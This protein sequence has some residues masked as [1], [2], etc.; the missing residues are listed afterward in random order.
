MIDEN[1]MNTT[2]EVKDE[3]QW[4][5]S[6]YRRLFESACDGI[7]ILDAETHKIIDV[8]PFML[9]LLGARRDEVIGRELREIGLLKDEEA[10]EIAFQELEAKGDVHYPV[11]P[12]E[13]YQGNL[14]E[15]EFTGGI[16]QVGARRIVQ[17]NIRDITERRRAERLREQQVQNAMMLQNIAGKA[18]HL[19]GWS[20]E[21]PERKLAWS[22]ENCLIH[23]LPP[24]YQPTLK[25]GLELFPEEHRAEVISYVERC[26]EEGLA[27]EF[28]LPKYT[29]KGRLIWVRSV[30]EAVR[31]ADGKIIRLQG[32]FQ[33]ITTRKQAEQALRES[34]EQY[35]QIIEHASDIIYKTNAT[36]RFS[37]VNPTIRK[38]LQYTEEELLSMHYLDVIRPDQRQAV[39][40]TYTRQLVRKT[41]NTYYELIAVAKDGTELW[42]GQH[43]QLLSKDNRVIGF[44]AICR[45]ITQKKQTEDQLRHLALTDE[46]TGLYN[47]R[48]FMALAEHQLKLA[49]NKR[50]EKKLLVLYVDLDGLKQINDR[51]GHDEGSRAIIRTAEILKQSF[52]HSDL[53]ARLGGDEFVVLAI[54]ANEEN[55]EMIIAR[56]QENFKNHNAQD[57][58]PCKIA[59]SFGIARFESELEF[60][61]ENLINRADEQMYHQKKRK[62]EHQSIENLS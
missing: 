61:I 51:F 58:H 57:S 22:D 44:Q 37:F 14:L 19:G 34:E 15:V 55:T 28:E 7:F 41:P 35:K 16:C 48:G 39:R 42:L 56:L 27:Y 32:A 38:I 5:D 47:R 13:T 4:S 2:A 54:E 53:V 8:N 10:S 9:E 50:I 45:D 60:Q 59:I 23:D 33:D 52:R 40:R 6:L 20:I 36:G 46:L 21:L 43:T 29:A 49:L 11:L 62:K 3:W 12:L 31:D 1:T 25:E 24:G 30:G 26:A 18:A 17:C